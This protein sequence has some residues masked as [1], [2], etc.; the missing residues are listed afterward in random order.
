MITFLNS[1]LKNLIAWSVIHCGFHFLFDFMEQWQCGYFYVV[2][3]IHNLWWMRIW[4]IKLYPQSNMNMIYFRSHASEWEFQGKTPLSSAWTDK[5]SQHPNH[6]VS[7]K[8]D[9]YFYWRINKSR[10]S[11]D[12]NANKPYVCH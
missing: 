10:L 8:V 11:I 5:Q 2:H 6:I 7:G 1:E 4:T 3:V 9:K 12:S